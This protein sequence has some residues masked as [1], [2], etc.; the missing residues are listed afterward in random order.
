MTITAKAPWRTKI[1]MPWK[2]WLKI[3]VKTRTLFIN[4]F[5]VFKIGVQATMATFSRL[6]P[7]RK[8]SY[9]NRYDNIIQKNFTRVLCTSTF[10]KWSKMSSRE[11]IGVKRKCKQHIVILSREKARHRLCWAGIDNSSDGLK[12]DTMHCWI[13]IAKCNCLISINR[14]FLSIVFK[15]WWKSHVEI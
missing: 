13:L 14:N 3:F 11:V 5:L 4:S 6:R 2:I 1:W 10:Q 15:H 9:N 7:P 8:E 12:T